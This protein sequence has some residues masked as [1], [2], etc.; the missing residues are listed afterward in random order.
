MNVG[1]S[2]EGDARQAALSRFDFLSRGY[3]G[4]QAEK[5]LDILKS[6]IPHDAYVL[7]AGCGVGY[8]AAVLADYFKH[9]SGIDLSKY[10]VNCAAKS[11]P[12][13]QKQFFVTGSVFNLPFHDGSLDCVVSVF[14]PCATPEFSRVLKPGGYI[15]VVGA[16]EDHLMGL[17]RVLYD[18]PYLNTPRKDLPGAG[19]GYALI[20]KTVCKTDITVESREMIDA[21]FS[22]TPY[23][24]RTSPSDREK[25]SGLCELQTPVCFDYYVY[26]KL[27]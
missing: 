13:H 27:S 3:Y 2:G 5:L 17:K 7:D 11:F 8:Y 18:N 12:R 10:A 1:D 24:W 21:L 14:A 22:M 20:N 23:Y 16:G 6:L 9:V 4:K 15:V 25:L 19:D 26:K